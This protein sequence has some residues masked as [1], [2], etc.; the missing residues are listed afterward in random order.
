MIADL[1]RITE[2][3]GPV[4]LGAG[5][6]MLAVALA[7]ATTQGGTSAQPEPTPRVT[8]TAP[9]TSA[10]G[11]VQRTARP[12]SKSS[13]GKSQDHLL[14]SERPSSQA[15]QASSSGTSGAGRAAIQPQPNPAPSP[16][17][18]EA[19]SCGGSVIAVQLLGACVSIGE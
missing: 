1:K 19:A 12:S 9:S 13:P 15:R 14:L 4:I 2:N 8:V 11:S 5:M 10:T 16:Q 18:P 6:T 7:T 3:G 17:P